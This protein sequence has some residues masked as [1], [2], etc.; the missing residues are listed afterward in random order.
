MSQTLYNGAVVPTNGDAYDLTADLVKMCLSLNVPI[1]VPNQAGRDALA[2]LA[3]SGVLPVGTMVLRKDQSM[4]VEK[5]DGTNW[6]TAS[7]SE[8]YRTGTAGTMIPSTTVYGVGALTIDA[9]KTSDAAF[10]THP[11]GDVLQFR[12]AGTY[13]IT[14]T[15]KATAI[16]STRAFI[17]FDKVGASDPLRAVAT[18]EDRGLVVIPNYRAAANEQVVFTMYHESGTGRQVDFRIRVTRIA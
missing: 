18:G 1:P 5:W 16:L 4:F 8:W 15:A 14:F 12:D 6:R 17:Q 11:A 10:V 7:H 9:A 3:P 13:A 2:G